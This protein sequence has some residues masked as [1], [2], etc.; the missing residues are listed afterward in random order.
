MAPYR[1]L[2]L[3]PALILSACGGGGATPSP[4]SDSGSLPAQTTSPALTF[5]PAT[6]TGATVEGQAGTISVQAA[7]A[8][9]AD[10]PAGS[11]LYYKISGPADVFASGTTSALA[12]NTFTTSI[13]TTATLAEGR[14]SGNLTVQLC[15]DQNCDR[16]YLGSP[17]SLPYQ[18][19][20]S[21]RQ[22]Y[23]E[24]ASS[25]QFTYRINGAAVVPDQIRVVGPGRGWTL[26]SNATWLKPSVSS[27]AG[28]MLVN[29]GVDPAGLEPGDYKG[30]LAFQTSAGQYSTLT[31][32]LEVVAP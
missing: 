28:I 4:T 12:G 15:P 24:R 3:V 6:V 20:V 19:D 30:D 10:F 26:A 8:R 11:Q 14:H 9:P 21:A 7:L 5:T 23:V 27:G 29:I 22:L 25:G 31:Y 32:L 2:A 1:L 16:Q 17:M 13:Q 18:I